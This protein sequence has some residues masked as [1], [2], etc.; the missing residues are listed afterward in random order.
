MG[1]KGMSAVVTTLIIILLAI[2]A[3]G[4]MWVV[5]K[6]VI[7]K[8]EEG[9]SLTGLVL[10]LEIQKAS[11]D[12]DTLSVTVHRKS[13]EGNL[14][15]INFV[16]GDGSDSEVVKREVVL[17]ELG[18]EIFNFNLNELNVGFVK[19][20]FIAPILKFESKKEITGDVVNNFEFTN[21]KVIENLGGISWWG[22]GGNANDEIINNNG[23]IEGAN[24]NVEGKYGKACSFEDTYVEINDNLDFD[25]FD[26]E[27]SVLAWA[28]P[29]SWDANH[30]TIICQESGF[31]LAIDSS[32]NLANWVYANSSWE[33]D[34]S[35]NPLIPLNEW[36][37]FVMTYDGVKIRSYVNGELQGFGQNKTGDMGIANK[38]YIGKRSGT[39][40]PFHGVIDEPMIF[41]RVLTEK[42][43]EALYKLDLIKKN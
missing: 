7:S 43:I 11:V 19:E 5:V 9:I 10:D 16:I 21:K 20:I 30:N 39:S 22:F 28:K 25:D 33:K 41:N 17:K 27:F 42:E 34:A 2:V 24:C 31:L 36:T 37:H 32:G 6:N 1:K 29:V 8:G 40:Q 38:V 13:G 15:G 4:I 35:S 3:I 23:V 12:E 14:V 18:Y 26:T